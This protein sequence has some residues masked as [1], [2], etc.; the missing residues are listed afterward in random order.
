[1]FPTPNPS[2]CQEMTWPLTYTDGINQL[3]KDCQSGK[4]H[5]V[6]KLKRKYLCMA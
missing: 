4:S 6:A 2:V 5:Y 3:A 1:M